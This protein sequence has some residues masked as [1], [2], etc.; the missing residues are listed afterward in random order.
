M[1]GVLNLSMLGLYWYT[2]S[3]SIVASG[4]TIMYSVRLRVSDR[5]ADKVR[6][7]LG[8]LPSDDVEVIE[9]DVLVDTVAQIKLS[10][11]TLNTRG[12]HF[13]RDEANAR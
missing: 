7:F 8:N 5:V 13:D 3:R 11:T 6:W 1:S 2:G 12:W 10:A 4:G 9:D